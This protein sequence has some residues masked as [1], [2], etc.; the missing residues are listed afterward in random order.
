MNLPAIAMPKIANMPDLSRFGG[1]ATP[2]A[3]IVVSILISVFVTWP[4][5]SE[6]MKLRAANQELSARLSSLNEKA[7]TLENLSTK[8]E[9]LEFLLARS[10]LL[11]PSEK[12]V[13]SLISQVEGVSSS[14]G[15]L[16]NRLEV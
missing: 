8:R 11:L 5:F 7:G 13:F 14:S 3:A 10:E 9:Q 15:I 16:L 6:V 1:M 4:K 12:N 2:S